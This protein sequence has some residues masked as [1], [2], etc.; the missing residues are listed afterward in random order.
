MAHRMSADKR[1]KNILEEVRS[2]AHRLQLWTS[3][4]RCWGALALLSLAVLVLERSTGWGTWLAMPLLAAAAF[5]VG[6]IVLVRT[7]K[8]HL[9]WSQVAHQIER[10]FPQLDG[11]LLTAVQQTSKDSAELNY[12]QQKVLEET[13]AFS[14]KNDWRDI[15]PK[16]HI[17]LAQVGHWLAVVI[18]IITILNLPKTQS[19]EF[20]ARITDFSVSVVPG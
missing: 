9:T 16:E 17:T 14:K 2:R 8:T 20:L 13:L 5:I 18:L 12:L 3:L 1:L 11:R 15:V 4:A 19:H 6:F 10:K 7:R